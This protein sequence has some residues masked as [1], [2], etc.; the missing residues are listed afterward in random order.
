MDMQKVDSF[1]LVNGKYFNQYQIAAIRSLLLEAAETKWIGLQV[2]QFKDPTLCL[3]LSLL[4]GGLG[5]DRFFVGDVGLG[6]LKLF[7]CGGFG[8]WTIID[9]FLIMGTARDRNF[10]K[11]RLLF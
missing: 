5:I 10:Q 11:L 8:I 4:V 6:L 9:W 3:I 2:L 1:I 7:T